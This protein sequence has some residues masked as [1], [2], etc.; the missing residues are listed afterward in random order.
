MSRGTDRSQQKEQVDTGR[1]DGRGRLGENSGDAGDSGLSGAK[2]DERNRGSNSPRILKGSE[3]SDSS[4][5][6]AGVCMG[7]H[8]IPTYLKL[9]QGCA[10]L[11]AHTPG[12][13]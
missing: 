6:V 2:G 10:M 5:S 11:P 1:G 12:Q 8:S 3:A 4:P 9:P 13:M 7:L